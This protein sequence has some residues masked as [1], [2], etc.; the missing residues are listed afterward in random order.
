M[1]EKEKTGRAL[2]SFSPMRHLQDLQD[3]IDRLWESL[4]APLWRSSAAATPQP[5]A[6][7]VDVL[8]KDGSVVI[9]AE[10]PGLTAADIEIT[11]SDEAVILQG[12]KSEEKETKE[13]DYYRC[14]RSYG[15]FS[16]HIALPGRGD[17]D[18]ATAT[19]K[20]GVLEVEVPLQEPLPKQTKVVIKPAA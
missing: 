11:V 6:P 7:A 9:K 10:L 16:R 8:R 15:R 5:W 13:S 17:P 4:P 18:R 3:E 1:A 2:S 20:D 14:E 12:E 19:F